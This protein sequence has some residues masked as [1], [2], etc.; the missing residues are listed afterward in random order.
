[1][2]ACGKCGKR[3]EDA[4]F[5]ANRASEDGLTS[6]CRVCSAEYQKARRERLNASK[7][8]EWKK[9][10]QDMSGYMKAWR[11][12]HPGYMTQAKREWWQKNRDKLKVKDTLR[13]AIKTGKVVKLPCQECGS[14][15]SQAHH[16]D[17]SKPLDVIWLCREHHMEI[18]R[19]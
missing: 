11:E 18:H 17:Y 14:Q 16:P 4:E 6:M 9:K 7:P 1:M 15:D 10:T 19:G 12:S 13:Y 2:K 3:K 5:Y 8:E